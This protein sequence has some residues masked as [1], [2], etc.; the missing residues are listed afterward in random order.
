ME[1]IRNIAIIAHVDHGKTTL[2]DQLL[3]QSQ[4]LR[5]NQQIQT[6]VMDSNDIERERGITILAKTTS[7]IY[8]DYRINVLD[9]PGHADFGGEVERI[10]KMVDG[11]LLLVDAKD[12]VMPQ[13]KFVLRKALE[14][15]LKPI[16]VINKV[17]RPFADPLNALNQV[18]DLFIDLNA[19]EEQLEFP[20]VYASGLQ[21]LSTLSE[22]FTTA[23]DMAPL[24]DT[25]VKYVPAPDAKQGP[26]QFQPALIDYN[27]YVGRMGIGKIH[28]GQLKLNEQV[29]VIKAD[30]SIKQFRIQKIYRFVGLNRVEA[31]TA[32][33][34]D[35]VAISGLADIHVGDTITAVGNEEAL[36]LLH[37]D[38]PTVQM[39]FSTNNSPF[40]GKEG[41]FVTA[42][43]I[44]E[45][46]Y[47]ETQKDVSLKVDRESGAESWTV[48]GRG[49]LHLGI[50]IE[51]M[52][53]EGYEFQV[54]R[55][56]VII[57]E[58]DGVKCEPYEEVQVDCP[59]ESMGTVIELLG[60]RKA[61]LIKM[62][63][64]GSQSRIH[65]VM[66]S[67]GLIGLMTQ[68]LTS[69]KGYGTLNHVYLDYRPMVHA[70]VGNRTLGALISM[71]SGMTTAYALGR[72]EDRGIMFVDPRTSVYEGMVVGESN[73]DI[74]L[75]VNVV[76]EK[77]L[78]NMRSAGKDST[79]VLKKPKTMS[80]EACL[81]F[82]NDD[83][84]VEITP[85]SIR[86][87]KMYLSANERKKNR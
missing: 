44:D 73:K 48:S 78:T 81:E 28:R 25:I 34:G 54:S 74:D 31:E 70:T 26:L 4:T 87:R 62:E 51:T 46:L 30:G 9:T 22:D 63:Q 10:M 18:F 7:I 67:R 86:I 59:T 23:V 60:E 38:E 20:V 57:R 19:S 11:V 39:T 24:L 84:L 40:A 15:N 3:K 1:K 69:T 56:K 16:V 72:L 77:Q 41:K 37:I 5:E 85:L 49:E 53:R 33:A 8:N 61:D 17:D 75:V 80:L 47:R 12:G 36:P 43:K 42:S 52:R 83:E 58:I 82:I 2:V 21:G 13:T 32:D 55:P 6:R 65:Y 29:S 76:Q 68:F 79:V 64:I 14:Q 35:I 45:R 27:E 71:S 50:L 66:P